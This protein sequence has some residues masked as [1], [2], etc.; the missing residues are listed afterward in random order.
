MAVS[1]HWKCA[2]CISSPQNCDLCISG[3]PSTFQF[4]LRPRTDVLRS[5]VQLL[6]P[7]KYFSALMDIRSMPDFQLLFSSR[8]S[9]ILLLHHA[10]S[11]LSKLNYTLKTE[12]IYSANLIAH[13]SF[14]LQR[15]IHLH[16]TGIWHIPSQFHVRQNMKKDKNFTKAWL[17]KTPQNVSFLPF[18]FWKFHLPVTQITYLIKSKYSLFKFG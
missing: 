7:D 3:S 4:K 6:D 2:C 1:V 9:I 18:F 15:K 13:C 12:I 8:I 11:Q 17:N 10:M 5:P 16:V 14:R